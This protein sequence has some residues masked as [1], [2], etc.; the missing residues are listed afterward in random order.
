MISST[1]ALAA[2]AS[3]PAP[4][5]Q[6][7]KA[8]VAIVTGQFATLDATADS[9][10]S[11]DLNSVFVSQGGTSSSSS[12]PI[13]GDFVKL[14]SSN[15]KFNI[16]EN[17]TEFYT[18]LDDD[19]LG[20]LLASGEYRNDA[21]NDFEYDQKIALNPA[22]QMSHFIDTEYS[23]LIGDDDDMPV[24]GFDL[25][26]NQFVLNYTIDFSPDDVEGGLTGTTYANLEE[27]DLPMLGRTYYVL[28]A[29]NT[30][31]Q[32]V[33]TLLDTSVTHT[34]NEGE[35][36]TIDLGGT[37]FEVKVDFVGETEVDFIVNG[38]SFD[39]LEEGESQQV[40]EGTYLAIKSI[41]YVSKETGVSS[42]VFSLGSGKIELTG[43]GDD[44]EIN[45]EDVEGLKSYV[46]E[47]A[48]DL[49]K[50]VL[51]WKTDDDAWITEQSDL[52]MPAF[53]S[54]RFSM[55]ATQTTL[56]ELT[57]VEHGS[58]SYMRLNTEVD[59]G[60]INLPFLF[61][62]GTGDITGFGKGS[63]D[64]RL[65]T[66]TANSVILD[67]DSNDRMVVTWIDGDDAVS[68]VLEIDDID[69]GNVALNTTTLKSIVSGSSIGEALDVGETD[70]IGNG[71]IRLTLNRAD[72]TLNTA[73]I[74]VSATS[75]TAYL[76]RLVTQEGLTVFLPW[77]SANATLATGGFNL[78]NGSTGSFTLNF[79]EEDDDGDIA[80]GQSFTATI[81][82]TTEDKVS[83]TGISPNE[84][85]VSDGSDDYEF[86]MPSQLGTHLLFKTGNDQD[87]LDITY[88]GEE[89][90]ADVFVAEQSSGSTGGSTSAIGN[91][92][93]TD[94]QASAYGSKNVIVIGGSCIN[95]A[96]RQLIDSTATA[97]I[98]GADFT[99]KTNV[100]AGEYMIKAFN[101]PWST[102]KVAVLVAGYEAD[103]TK[104]GATALRDKKLDITAGKEYTGQ[105]ATEV[106]TVA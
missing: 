77:N 54:V 43:N 29:S 98:C 28:D 92:V 87:T 56:E 19:E 20:T 13:A 66:T 25:S 88:H 73:N 94:N 72:A 62:N 74:T 34:V 68:Y 47:S 39:Q 36:R 64:E 81:G 3:Y 95:T 71:K 18:T 76:N 31:S 90:W 42:V 5:V 65:I 24:I 69:S 102:G 11:T 80:L 1:V 53:E 97:A 6:N 59:D 85:R 45:G 8:D 61:V 4:F 7:G 58:S 93:V 48:G 83:V 23:E 22:L 96:A 105:T 26:N 21:G 49:D 32:M 12:A 41:R 100:G 86:Y 2:A 55:D 82:S 30:S 35:T 101:S 84:L 91:I 103:D 44:V 40:V 38:E 79:T 89:L 10:L 27:T 60:E 63:S 67:S 50:I 37:A 9:I 78:V 106:T 70:D 52:V 104:N 99:S 33:F 17:M 15:D 57:T 16:G 75:G 14:E 51:E 46:Y